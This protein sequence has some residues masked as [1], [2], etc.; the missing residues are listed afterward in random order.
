[1]AFRARRVM[2]RRAIVRTAAVGGAAYYAGK[3]RERRLGHEAD[4]DAQLETM[5]TQ[6]Y[7]QQAAPPA[8]AEPTMEDKIEQIKQLGQL[9]ADGVLTD[10]EFAAQKR[11]I[12][13]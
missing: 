7:E 12:L 4:Q 9:H 11:E 10:E 8:P 2:R 1:M 6:G 13:G 5:P 3:G